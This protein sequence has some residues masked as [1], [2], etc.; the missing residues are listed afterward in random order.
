MM[1][2]RLTHGLGT[3]FLAALALA[4][5]LHSQTAEMTKQEYFKYVPLSYPRIIR[6]TVADSVF[7][8]YGALPAAGGRDVSP[9][10]ASRMAAAPCCRRSASVSRRS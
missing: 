5:P 10:T 8:L 7:N 2:R 1:V 9:Q 3:G 6:Q 4:N